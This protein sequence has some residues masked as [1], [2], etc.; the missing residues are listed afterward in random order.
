MRLPKKN[1]RVLLMAGFA[2]ALALLVTWNRGRPD[3][4][5]HDAIDT[6]GLMFAL[7]LIGLYQLFSRFMDWIWQRFAGR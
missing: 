6:A 4:V 5:A 7:L 2:A 3:E 1:K